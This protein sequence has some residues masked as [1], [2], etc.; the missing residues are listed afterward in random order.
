MEGDTYLY[1]ET[2]NISYFYKSI[3]FDAEMPFRLTKYTHFSLHILEN[4]S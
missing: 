3:K 4:Y 1:S 2:S